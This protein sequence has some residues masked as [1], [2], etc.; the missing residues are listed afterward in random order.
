MPN[1][2]VAAV[3]RDASVPK[4]HSSPYERRQEEAVP[5][6]EA[7]LGTREDETKGEHQTKPDLQASAACEPSSTEEDGGCAACQVG[8]GEGATASLEE[9]GLAIRLIPPAVIAVTIALK[10]PYRQCS[11]S[12]SSVHPKPLMA[13]ALPIQP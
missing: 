7:A 12:F 9:G 4:R 11:G 2:A 5:A 6:A 8:E 13:G 3:D 1:L 10:S